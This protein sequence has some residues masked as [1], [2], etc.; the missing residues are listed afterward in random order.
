MKCPYCGEEVK[1]KTRAERNVEAYGY[2]ARART[3]CCGAVVRV[4]RVITFEC[5]KTSQDELDDWDD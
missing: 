5:E 3:L 2:P 1:I 4:H